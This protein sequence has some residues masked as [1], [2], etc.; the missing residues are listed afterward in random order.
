MTKKVLACASLLCVLTSCLKDTGTEAN[1]T[2]VDN[3]NYSNASD[4]FENGATVFIFPEPEEG[5]ESAFVSQNTIVYFSKSSSGTLF[6]GFALSRQEWTAPE[7]DDSDDPE[8]DGSET[9]TVTAPEPCSVYGKSVGTPNTFFYFRQTQTMPEHDMAFA[10]SNVGTCTPAGVM[11]C[12]SAPTVRKIRGENVSEDVFNLN[13]DYIL[14]ATGYLNGQKTGSATFLLAGKGK[15]KVPATEENPQRD[16][17]V[18]S[19]SPFDLSKL[20]Q[21]DYIDFDLSFSNSE[22]ERLL[23]YTDV[24][25]DNFTASIH[26]KF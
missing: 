18:T 9:E 3:G 15:S 22:D 14:T 7:P 19:W 17:I 16:S 1:Y 11:V 20:G 6:G 24:C 10:A 21:I 23:D 5:D 4:F 13:G 26:L 8:S 12:N 25:L 2:L